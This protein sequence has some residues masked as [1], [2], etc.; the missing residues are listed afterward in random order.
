LDTYAGFIESVASVVVQ[1]AARQFLAK[2]KT[3]KM[4]EENEK[5]LTHDLDRQN[6]V[7][8]RQMAVRSRKAKLSDMAR[9]KDVE[10]NMYDVAAVNI[11]AVFRGWNLR[12]SLTV[13]HYCATS[14]Q[15]V[16][17]GFTSLLRYNT[18][19][20]CIRLIQA[21]FRG[22]SVRKKLHENSARG[23]RNE[24][25]PDV[26]AV[27]IQTRWRGY[28]SEMTFLRIYED[29]VFVQKVVRGWITRRLLR[30][31]LKAHSVR[32]SSRLMGEDESSGKGSREIVSP[33]RSAWHVNEAR[34]DN[35]AKAKEVK[36]NRE[37]NGETLV[38]EKKHKANTLQGGVVSRATRAELERRRKEKEGAGED[39]NA[40]P[41]EISRQGYVRRMAAFAAKQQEEKRI[42]S[43]HQEEEPLKKET[44]AQAACEEEEFH[45]KEMA[46]KAARDEEVIRQREIA[47]QAFLE[48]EERLKREMAAPAARE[49]E[50]LREK[51]MA[52]Q[53]AREE[54][55]HR[56]EEMI[57]QTAREEE[58]RHQ[59]EIAA[60]AAREEEE[61]ERRKREVAAQ[62][63]R[64]EERRSNEKLPT[65][66][67]RPD[68][69]SALEITYSEK[70]PASLDEASSLKSRDED[71]VPTPQI[72]ED[73]MKVDPNDRA[74][75]VTMKLQNLSTS[76]DE[77]PKKASTFK[78]QRSEEEQRRIDKIHETFHRVGLMTRQKGT[79]EHGGNTVA[80]TLGDPLE[81]PDGDE[82]A[83]V[84][85]PSASDLIQA[86]RSRDQTLPKMNGKLF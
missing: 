36:Q 38:Q 76:S 50:E 47:A 19:L 58:E 4:R 46:A 42:R 55:E 12:D 75:I 68:E 39:Q 85:E 29:I 65:P 9:S 70:P 18:Q 17:R 43:S 32:V 72:A 86:W 28:A 24:H 2:I 34:R 13:D 64:E 11:Q 81:K 59:S 22:H 16:F 37:V 33:G 15:T 69:A 31:W 61:E 5:Q 63:A 77:E 74:A 82:T 80:G 79:N 3:R 26:A 52:A 62:A 66:L 7:R 40:S 48:E 14:I 67:P 25:T 45:K 57:A 44:A 23:F 21:V 10:H 1:T 56:K 53:A 30:A 60:Q 83:G 78:V 6:A 84:S 71:A 27:I 54:E 35:V 49:E 73:T 20:Y 51:E 8:R 41:V